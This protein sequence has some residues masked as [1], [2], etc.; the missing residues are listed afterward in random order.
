MDKEMR[1]RAA[2]IQ[3]LIRSKTD[4]AMAEGRGFTEDEFREDYETAWDI[5]RPR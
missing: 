4:E 3:A 5:H 1:A 2:A